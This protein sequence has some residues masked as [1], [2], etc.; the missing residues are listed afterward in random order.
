M[1]SASAPSSPEK[2]A[3]RLVVPPDQVKDDQSRHQAPNTKQGQRHRYDSP[4]IGQSGAGRIALKGGR[5][6]SSESTAF[7]IHEFRLGICRVYISFII[8]ESP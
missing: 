3:L 1:V 4:K 7:G 6:K 5:V 8:Y 2:S